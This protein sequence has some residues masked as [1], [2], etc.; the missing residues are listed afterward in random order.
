MLT[1]RSEASFDVAN[2][3]GEREHSCETEWYP[4][5]ILLA[6]HGNFETVTEINVH[7]LAGDTIKHKV[8][9]V[10]V[11][12]TKN[13]ANH[14]HD[15]ERARV[16]S[17]SVEPGFGAL[18]LEPENTVQVLACRVI[19]CIA[20]HFDLLHERKVVIV[21]CHLQHDSVLNVEQNFAALA[22]FTNENVKRIAVRH[23]S[24]K[25]G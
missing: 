14:G 2:L 18:T 3:H 11:A 8:G 6:V 13:V 21:R 19:Q 10:P 9:R 15:S 23:P 12:Q 24:E 1:R 7:D 5:W 4:F 17:T 16:V 22:I 20:E 25:T